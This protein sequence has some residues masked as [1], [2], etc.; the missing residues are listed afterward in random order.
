[1]CG[2]RLPPPSG[3]ARSLVDNLGR[4]VTKPLPSVVT[5]GDAICDEAVNFLLNPGDGVIANADLAREFV[6]R[7]CSVNAA[8]AESRSPLNF[9]E[10]D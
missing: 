6:A 5:L 10:A 4:S 1:M 7:H 9:C 2:N 3:L 8:G